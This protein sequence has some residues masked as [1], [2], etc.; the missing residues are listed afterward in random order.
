MAFPPDTP[1]IELAP[2]LP[3]GRRRFW[4]LF[5]GVLFAAAPSFGAQYDAV[6]ALREKIDQAEKERI[7]IC[8]TL[9][10]I[11][12][13]L[14][15][16][17]KAI[18]SYQMAFHV[19]PDDPFISGK[20]IKLYTAQERWAELAP[21]YKSLINVN[22]GANEVYMNKLAE[23]LLK[24]GQP[25]EALSVIRDLLDEYGNDSGDYRDAAQMLIN[26][27]QY[28]PAASICRKGIEAGFEQSAN[29]HCLLGRAAAKAGEYADAIFAYRKAIELSS[30]RSDRTLLEKELAELCKEEPI[31]KRILEEKTKSLRAID[32]RL[33]ELY[34]QKAFQ[35]QQEGKLD[36]AIALYRKIV[37]LVLDS[38]R[39]KAAKKKIQ[40]LSNP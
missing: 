39:G 36:A 31:I 19:F 4:L 27:E 37:S 33:A 18:E 14:G 40:E 30:S 38:E 16:T 8:R 17:D 25:G 28:Q 23:C 5:A 32:K 22:P 13:Q 29:L 3:S 15:D 24:A 6:S 11:Y 12:E 2:L 26:Y 20:L 7:E 34:W 10:A 35:K 1:G 9:G 21:V